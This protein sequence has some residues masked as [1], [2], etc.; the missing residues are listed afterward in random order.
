MTCEEV[1]LELPAVA[2]G[3]PV[4]AEVSEHLSSC[5]A[6]STELT[7]IKETMSFTQRFGISQPPEALRHEVLARIEAAS[8]APALGLAV[9]PPPAS[10]KTSI[11]Q[12]VE[13]ERDRERSVVTPMKSR[14]PR[15]AAALAAAATL[16]LVGAAIGSALQ[17][18]A[19]DV[20]VAG[21]IPVGH[22]TQMLQIEGAGPAEAEV[23]HYRHDNFRIT[24]SVEGFEPTPAGSHY[25]VWVRGE[26][27]DV[28]L[29]TFRIKR[30][31]DF[32]IPFA[33]GVNPDDYPTFVVTLEP[34]DGNP[35]LTGEVLSHGDF[36]LESVHHGS[37]DE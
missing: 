9:S 24:L 14:A 35:A 29:G 18:D 17:P 21:E 36:D 22:E 13:E 26:V 1:L 12:A 4:P 33:M 3:E 28:A 27:G 16:L 10:L 2:G 5:T 8:I 23:D 11:M 20:E 25:A 6:C 31:D 7:E 32:V 15:F 30:P 19:P 37:Y 34:N